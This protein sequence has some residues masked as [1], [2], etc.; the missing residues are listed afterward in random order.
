M[1]EQYCMNFLLIILH[2]IVRVLQVFI[3]VLFLL[4]YHMII[5]NQQVPPLPS[6]LPS[7]L[8]NIVHSL[9]E[10]ILF[11]PNQNRKNQQNDYLLFNYLL[12]FFLINHH[13][14]LLL[15][16]RQEEDILLFLLLIR[17]MMTMRYLFLLIQTC[18]LSYEIVDEQN[19]W[20]WIN[21]QQKIYSFSFSFSKTIS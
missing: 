8:V 18:I 17:I 7:S 20:I 11:I 15:F 21:S 2:L 4:Q 19:C 10:V 1:I 9:L 6:I 12:S 14:F 5:I 3:N 16:K 13:L